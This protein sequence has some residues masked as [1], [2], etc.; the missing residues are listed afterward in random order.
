MVDVSLLF[1]VLT[2]FTSPLWKRKRW[3]CNPSLFSILGISQRC[4]AQVVSRSLLQQ[5]FWNVYLPSIHSFK[6]LR[7]SV[8]KVII[9]DVR[10]SR[11]QWHVVSLRM[12]SIN[13]RTSQIALFHFGRDMET[14]WAQRVEASPSLN[15]YGPT[16]CFTAFSALPF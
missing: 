3:I 14:S 15:S 1:S 11:L 7:L 8:L 13:L 10:S 6:K 9:R 4:F 16:Y 2:H 5:K 12:Y